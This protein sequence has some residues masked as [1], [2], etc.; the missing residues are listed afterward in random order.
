MTDLTTNYVGLKLRSPII[1]GSAGITET[2]KRMKKA[3][4]NGAGA[5]VM[6]SLFE[7]KISRTSPT[8]RFK[9][10]DYGK[11]LKNNKSKN[12]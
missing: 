5:V 10:I 7:D 3:E 12:S 2:V 8:P 1:A 9:L 4:D 6:K 11:G